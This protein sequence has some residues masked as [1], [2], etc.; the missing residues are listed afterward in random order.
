M[1]INPMNTVVFG[2]ASNVPKAATYWNEE[3][4]R[5]TYAKLLKSP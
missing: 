3:R 5:G 1:T 4:N 2:I